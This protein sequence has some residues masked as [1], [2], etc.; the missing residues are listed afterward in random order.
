MSDVL[1]DA[2]DFLG[3]SGYPPEYFVTLGWL[4]LISIFLIDRYGFELD[5]PGKMLSKYPK[6]VL[7]LC[8]A[9][10]AWTTSLFFLAGTARGTGL[11]GSIEVLLYL[12][13]GAWCISVLD[14]LIKKFD[15]W[16]GKVVS[17]EEE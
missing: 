7:L 10:F 14:N 4:I 12:I 8:V 17:S 1:D 5:N 15:A 9:I 13:G 16:L 3:L 6:F 11:T 2:L